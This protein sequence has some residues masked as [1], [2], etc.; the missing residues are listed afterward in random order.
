MKTI[1]KLA[2]LAFSLPLFFTSCNSDDN[3]GGHISKGD[4]ENGFFVL[5]EGNSNLSTAS[6]TFV[7][8]DG[9]VEQDIF[10]TINPDAD[11]IGTYLQNIFFDDTRAFIVS[12]GANMVT[13]VN[14]YTFEYITTITTNLSNPRY[15]V[16]S[17]GKAFVT[18]AGNFSATG[19][20]VTVI[21]LSD[22][23]TS[24]LELNTTAERIIEEDGKVY[25]ANG[26]FGNGNTITVINGSTGTV[27]A[28]IDL[29]TGNIPST[30]D[31]ENGILYVLTKTKIL[32]IDTSNNSVSGTI[33][34]PST[35]T[36]PNN[37]TIEDNKIYFTGNSTSVY[38]LGLNATTISSIPVLTYE[39]NSQWGA[40][41]G[42]AVEDGKI[43]VADAGDFASDS[44]IYIYS[45]SGTL[46]STYT[47]G[48]GPN[49]FYFND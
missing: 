28:T 12:G 23:S 32:K 26:Y 25:V 27:Q 17:S 38:A 31:E 8:N 13:V 36:S 4:F 9:I 43:Y 5:N 33:E 44:E 11:Q 1:K 22:Y 30:L 42:F 15:G 16:T 3:E 7:G 21:N 37:L 35:I 18:N 34:I 45:T 10:R 2:V 19:G 40:M 14:R 49:G 29:G 20:S 24:K 39:S 48:V 6:V 41:Y 46:L 47:V